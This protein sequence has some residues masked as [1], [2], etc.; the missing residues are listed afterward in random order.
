MFDAQTK[1]LNNMLYHY[2]P[3]RGKKDII[4]R[5][6]MP[7]F[8][9]TPNDKSSE[10]WK[11][12]D[13]RSRAFASVP[14]EF[15]NIDHVDVIASCHSIRCQFDADREDIARQGSPSGFGRSFYG[16]IKIKD[17]LLVGNI[18]DIVKTKTS[19][20]KL[21]KWKTLYPKE[22][23]TLMRKYKHEPIAARM[24]N[25]EIHTYH[26]MTIDVETGK[27]KSKLVKFPTIIQP[28]EAIKQ[29]TTTGKK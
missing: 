22:Y 9:C 3:Y 18:Y 6:K 28:G 7:V 4:D 27:V 17:G 23:R 1:S 8:R 25:R 12:Q 20:R 2:K 24:W 29:T 14:D 10:M 19:E 15:K 5:T 13:E 11:N 16:K 21:N 26:K